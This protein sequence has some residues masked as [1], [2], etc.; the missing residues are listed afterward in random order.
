VKLRRRKFLHL[1]AGAAALSA[2]SALPAVAS[3]LDYPTRPVHFIVAFAAGGPT[4]TIARILAQYLSEYLGQQFVV[5]NRVGAGG[6]IGMEAV[7]SA[8]PDGYTI[9][10]VAPNNAINTTLYQHLPFDFLHDSTPVAG[11]MKLANVMDVNLS[12]P[13]QNLAEFIAMAKA[14]P[15]KINFGSGGVGTSPHM[16]GELLQAMAGIELT[17]VPYRGTAPAMADLLGGQIQVLF[18][19]LPGSIQQIQAGRIRALGVTTA[20]RVDGLPDVPAIGET[21]PGYEVFVWFGICAPKGTRPEVVE[22]L[23]G[24]VNTVLANTKLIARFHELGGEPMAMTPAEFGKL[25]ADETDKWAKV[26]R[27]AHIKLE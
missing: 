1:A 23:N 26:I 2:F 20:K 3:A 4:D 11:T 16:S 13:A 6:N 19:N 15:G 21:V 24:A 9:G 27:V 14:N 5:E 18:D 12:F 8:P 22:K 25:I 17:H 7:L 10:F